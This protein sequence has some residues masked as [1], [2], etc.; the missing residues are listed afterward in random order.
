MTLPWVITAIIAGMMCTYTF[1]L[2]W[3]EIKKSKRAQSKGWYLVHLHEADREEVHV[4]PLDDIGEH[5]YEHCGC[6]PVNKPRNHAPDGL[7]VH[8][9]WDV[10]EEYEA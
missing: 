2:I 1:T 5:Y 4:M 10:R 3:L 6:R 8:N 7:I 9:S